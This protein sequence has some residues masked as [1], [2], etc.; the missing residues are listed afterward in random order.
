MK[1]LIIE[2]ILLI[3][4][5]ILFAFGFFL[6]YRQVA[7]VKRGEFRNKDRFQCIIYGFIF[8][9]AIMVVVGVGFIFAVKTPELWPNTPPDI[10]PLV[11]LIPFMFS[12][13]YMT[14]YPLID[15]LFIALSK[16]SDEGLTP[17]QRFI[18]LKVI[19]KFNN[20][21]VAV[22]TALSFYLVVFI[23]PP[24]ILSII[25]LPFIMIWI[26]WM[27]IYPLMILTF[28]GSKG[29]IAG[30][31]N[32]YYHIPYISRSM[33][34]NFEDPKRG[35]KQFFSE[36]IHYIVLGLMLFVFVWAWISLFQ[37]IG[38]F[39][40]GSLA[41]STMS[42]VFVFVT[43]FFGI[44]GYFTR[45]W[46]RK[47]KYRGIDIYFAAYLMSCIGINVLVNFLIVNPSKLFDTFNLW[48]ITSQINTNSI[49]FAWAAVIEEIVLIIFTSYFFLARKNEFIRNIKF[50]K[51]TESGQSFDPIPLFNFIKNSDP[52]IRKNS[53][54]ALLLMFER[55]P[56]KSDIDLNNWKFKNPL[57]DGL[58]DSD[59]DTR[60]I[61]YQIFDQLSK[62]IPEVILPWI[63]ESLESPNYEKNIPILKILMK[64]DNLF[65]ENIPQHIIF[66]LL[67]ESEWRLKLYGLKLF[68]RLLKGKTDLIQKVN[69]RKFMNDPNSKIQIEILNILAESSTSLPYDVII[70]KIFNANNEIRAAAIKNLKNL[71][72]EGLDEKIVLKIIP[73]M[74]DPSSTVRASI[75]GI[76]ANIG[77]FKK[78]K[79]PLLPLLEGLSDFDEEV[80]NAAILALMKYYEEI[81]NRLNLDE[82]INKIDPSNSETLNTMLRLLG[83][84]WKHNPEKILTTLLEYIRFEDDQLKTNISNILVEKYPIN[85]DIIIQNLIDIPD[86][87]GYLTKGTIAKTFI[88]IGRKDP[89]N[90]IKKLINFL[91]SDNVDAKL[92]VINVIGGLV[93]DLPSS[94]DIKPILTIMQEDQNK[95]LKK[96][97]S[98]LI[99][100]IAKNDPN[101]MKPLISEF[102]KSIS[103]Q[104]SSVQIVLFRSLL[105]IA[106]VSPELI[107]IDTIIN[108]LSDSDSFIRETNTK[109]LGLIG[110]RNPIRVVDVLINIALND[111]EWIVREAAVSSLGNIVSFIEDKKH[112]IE[113]LSSLLSDEESWVLRSVL[114]ILSKIQEVNEEYVPFGI[115]V[116]CLKSN[117]PKVREASANLLNIYSNQI[118]EIFDDIIILLGDI[119]E[120]VRTSTINSLVKIIQEV[121]INRILSKLLKNLSDEGT[122]E[123][124]RSIALLFGR[125]AQYE[126]EKTRKRIVSLLKIRCEMSQDP[127]IC[128]ILQKLKEG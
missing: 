126:D 68:S 23:L 76:F 9:L 117:D 28:Y 62:D 124:Q 111:E 116:K 32:A 104:D 106:S 15:F 2:I 121:G 29:Y 91:K 51:I 19:N 5:L 39:F 61:S 72:K 105:E 46:G 11:L 80:R 14:V 81:P 40:T 99:S 86:D 13:A 94:I 96:E 52:K 3:I 50:S 54:E 78:N 108:Y 128:N 93:D 127:I 89:L 55:I 59:I 56:L 33:F 85:P 12:L 107:P 101:V 21:L 92:N 10:N 115:L 36:P 30:I 57:L 114:I 69:F 74:K 71:S 60:R 64:T 119:V 24:I 83:R 82:I 65:L 67:E 98:K 100:R 70:D 1:I 112:I 41:I 6:I 63:I 45:F 103:N 25:G 8:S 102:I 17:F 22:L 79:I 27:L 43:L 109:I 34:L 53:E 35:M 66:N 122:I 123:I 84:L 26:S 88:E 58:C 73:A 31:S 49:M 110:Y 47:I 87:S 125:I 118:D 42:S 4:F 44:I 20:K 113:K 37:T 7:L 95:Q 75:F 120:E 77:R 90:L 38:F 18:S 48:N 16:E 97:A